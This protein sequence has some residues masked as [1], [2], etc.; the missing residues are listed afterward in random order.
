MK[1]AAILAGLS[2]ALAGCLPRP[3][4]DFRAAL[5][6]EVAPRELAGRPDELPPGREGF[7]RAAQAAAAILAE[8]A[9]S[10]EPLTRDAALGRIESAGVG[11]EPVLLALARERERPVAR[12][13]ALS[14]LARRGDRGAR[15]L[16]RK[17]AGS[18][19]P[20]IRARALLTL[21][22]RADADLLRAA[23]RSD[24]PR[25][26]LAALG[27]V[28]APRGAAWRELL[29]QRLAEDE[30]GAV[31]SLA[32]TRLAGY[33]AEAEASLRAALGDLDGYV[34]A[35][36]AA[37]LLEAVGARAAP[38][39]APL[40]AGAEAERALAL[41]RAI[42]SSAERRAATS[43]GE[44]R[45]VLERLGASAR[46]RVAL[47]LS[48]ADESQRAL[49]AGVLRSMQPRPETLDALRAALRATVTPR[50]R[51][52]LALA[53]RALGAE[54]AETTPLL[55]ELA[56]EPG[57]VGAQ[58]AEAAFERGDETALPCLLVAARDA[59]PLVRAVAAE[60]LARYGDEAAS[61]LFALDDP[62]ERVRTRWAAA[63]L[64][65]RGRGAT[66]HGLQSLS[67]AA[68]AGTSRSRSAANC[69]LSR[70]VTFLIS[71]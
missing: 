40:V 34:A 60:A 62:D 57:M 27:H 30:S 48:S 6:G 12:A 23:A 25:E 5:A 21:D 7:E 53:L 16:L 26:R 69:V 46:A 39:L 15:R 4:R 24:D 54:P 1:L 52:L 20:A 13:F 68:A 29:E 17:L 38:S 32:A 56:R 47:A 59:D 31:R 2:V 51:L 18:S 70:S 19:D 43:D 36:A 71:A 65:A 63:I 10:E 42:A 33:G 22:P 11:A 14:V 44:E 58:A 28:D 49:A 67:P 50:H 55:A 8:A 37:A 61:S 41:A 45:L 64:A 9:R 35:A 3:G 66:S